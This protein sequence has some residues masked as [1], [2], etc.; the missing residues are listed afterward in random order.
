MRRG[1]AAGNET[2][3]E[4]RISLPLETGT[5][6]LDDR[7][8]T[9]KARGPGINQPETVRV[10]L[11]GGFKASVG[12][13]VTEVDGWR[14]RKAATLIKLLS[15]APGHA[16]HRERVT[17]TL[18]PGL[19]AK[20]AANNLHRALH[21]ARRAFEGGRA[22][23]PSRFLRLQGDLLAL[24]PEDRLLVDVEV[25][26]EAAET[27]RHGRDPR[28]YRAAIGLYTGELLPEDLY[29]EWT[30][31]R[32]VG[33]LRLYRA[34]LLE[35]AILHE[36]RGEYG[37]AIGV[38]ERVVSEEPTNEEAHL[39]LV[40]LH[41]LAGR[42]GEALAHYER[43]R[44][45]LA[46]ELGTE[47]NYASRRLYEEL[48]AGRLPSASPRYS[49]RSGH[50]EHA[51]ASP[52]H[53]LPVSLTSFVGREREIPEIKRLLSMSRLLTLTGAGGCGKTR[54]A[55]E[56]ARDLLPLYPD[57]V[58]LVELAPLMDPTLVPRATASALGISERPGRSLVHEL[59]DHLRSRRALL[60]LDNC[61]HLVDACA[62]FAD[63][64]LSSCEGV[65]VLATS[66][67]RLGV[68][69]EVSWPV[70]PLAAPDAGRLPTV[71][72]LARY[73]AVGLFVDRAGS[74]SPGFSLTPQNAPA[75]AEVCGKLD[76]IPLVIELAAARMR[77]LSVEQI[78][79]RLDDSLR[80]LTSDTRTAEP[81]EQRD[82]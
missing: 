73:E 4:R 48:R 63:V 20:A 65:R 33:L 39:R 34:L 44:E 1:Y 52:P 61:E 42:R 81:S 12:S 21:F 70:L 23:S 5:E 59:F 40:R 47:P 11:L 45:A 16:L 50:E 58:W 28:A 32:R 37:A 68:A 18:W 71:A 57:G 79:D 10:W 22:N 14:L 51:L 17:D 30:Q 66:R 36:E 41:A 19:E 69:G 26:E 46:R 24:C 8:P 35:L 53:N 74:R 15:L 49:E 80:L 31:E 62:A 78:A 64:L 60:V 72:E 29:E 43:L 76:G 2:G 9:G 13:R 3:K 54:L 56:V 82:G 67:E 55:L 6:A 38:A 25:F 7:R 27:A 77:A 75:V